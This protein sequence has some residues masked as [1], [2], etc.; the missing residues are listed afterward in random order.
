[1]ALTAEQKAANK[2]QRQ[3]R[4]RAY[5][6][7]YNARRDAMSAALATLPMR[8]EDL[9]A[10]VTPAA[11][12]L[13]AWAADT[14]YDAAQ[15]AATLEEQSIREQI[16]KLQESLQGVRARHHLPEL[17]TVRREAYSALSLARKKAEDAVDAAYPDVAQ[18][19]SAAAWGA[20]VG[21]DVAAE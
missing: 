14:Q 4:D 6:A 3:A 9:G 21:F 19:H 8:K 15:R 20:K 5:R 7:R 16:A 18:T 11:V 13:E 12:V 1:M 2:E 17:A 10:G